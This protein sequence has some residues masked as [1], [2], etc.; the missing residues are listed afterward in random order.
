[1]SFSWKKALASTMLASQLFSNPPAVSA[2][3]P[4]VLETRSEVE[5]QTS[6]PEHNLSPEMD[7]ADTLEGKIV[8]KT[9]SSEPPLPLYLNWNL[10]YL[11][12]SVLSA[13]KNSLLSAV[14][15]NELTVSTLGLSLDCVIGSQDFGEGWFG[16]LPFGIFMDYG[17]THLFQ[18]AIEAVGIAT[19]KGITAGYKLKGNMEYFAVGLTFGPSFSYQK[20]PFSIGLSFDL[21]SGLTHIPGEIRIDLGLTDKTIRA[22]A[23]DNGIS[24]DA[25]GKINFTSMGAFAQV[26][27]GPI[28]SIYDVVCSGGAGLRYDALSVHVREG[29]NHPLLAADLPGNYQAKYNQGSIVFGAKCGYRF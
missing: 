28:F 20:G 9:H 10:F 12:P 27:A 4:T 23:L 8:G 6:V 26:L 29:A 1:M 13:P 16:T 3:P 7:A 24:P 17:S 18:S 25:T 11:N 21:K 5:K 14:N 15:T 2:R 19:H 22:I